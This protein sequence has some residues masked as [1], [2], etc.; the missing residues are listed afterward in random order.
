MTTAQNTMIEYINGQK[1]IA[2]LAYKSDET[3]VNTNVSFDVFC[4]SMDKMVLN[5]INSRPI[6]PVS[7]KKDKCIW[8]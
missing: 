1:E 5:H 4:S 3:A 2:F 7:N 6:N 8:E